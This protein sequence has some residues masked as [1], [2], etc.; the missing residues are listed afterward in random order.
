MTNNIMN[1]PKI[2]RESAVNFISEVRK[3]MLMLQYSELNS[4]DEKTK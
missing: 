3:L 1:V 2:V 4:L